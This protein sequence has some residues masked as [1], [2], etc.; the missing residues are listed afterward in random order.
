M[1][2]G[3]L[4]PCCCK[5]LTYIHIRQNRKLLYIHTYVI[6]RQNTNHCWRNESRGY[7]YHSAKSKKNTSIIRTQ[8]HK[9]R[10]GTS[11]NRTSYSC[12]RHHE[13]HRERRMTSA[14]AQSQDENPVHTSTY[15]QS[16]FSNVG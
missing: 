12:S 9:S 10:Q 11:G 8:I 2:H 7:Y 15:E 14:I 3:L 4:Y 5:G 1:L 16:Q 6:V 13:D